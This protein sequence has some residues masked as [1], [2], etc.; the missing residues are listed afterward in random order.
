MG[1]QFPFCIPCKVVIMTGSGVQNDI[2]LL[3]DYH[4]IYQ[5]CYDNVINFPSF[6]NT[7]VINT[8]LLNKVFVISRIIK[9]QETLIILDIRTSTVAFKLVTLHYVSANQGVSC[10]VSRTLNSPTTVASS[11]GFTFPRW[12]SNVLTKSWNFSYTSTFSSSLSYT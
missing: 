7:I 11:P 8:L 1:T 12:S 10:T 4:K 2:Y 3:W 6:F 9:V 5:L